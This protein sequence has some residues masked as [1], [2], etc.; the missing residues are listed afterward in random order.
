MPEPIDIDEDSHMR[1]QGWKKELTLKHVIT[2]GSQVVCQEFD[3]YAERMP[4][5]I[6]ESGFEGP[7]C[8][9]AHTWI[10]VLNGKLFWSCFRHKTTNGPISLSRGVRYAEYPITASQAIDICKETEQEIPKEIVSLYQREKTG[11]TM[12]T[13]RPKE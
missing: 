7:K 2:R 6:R 1:G 8:G 13:R 3:F 9:V 11:G 10:K 5:S 4:C 12:K